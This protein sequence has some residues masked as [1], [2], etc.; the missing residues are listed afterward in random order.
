MLTMW[1][2]QSGNDYGLVEITRDVNTYDGIVQK[3]TQCL[4]IYL[5]AEVQNTTQEFCSHCSF[6][7]QK[8]YPSRTIK[9]S[10]SVI[11]QLEKIVP[12]QQQQQ[13]DK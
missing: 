3:D 6:F 10:T 9:R 1:N 8:S 5:C 4:N 12:S 7:Q 11:K 13:K 2:V